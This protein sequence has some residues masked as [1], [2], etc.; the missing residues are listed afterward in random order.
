MSL[1]E[2]SEEEAGG[3]LRAFDLD[4]QEGKVQSVPAIDF[5]FVQL[6][7]NPTSR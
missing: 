1:I 6:G 3:D 4:A 5:E 7:D 2:G